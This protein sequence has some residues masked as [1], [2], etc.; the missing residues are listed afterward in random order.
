MK[1]KHHRHG[2]CNTAG[3]SGRF[4]VDSVIDRFNFGTKVNISR[5]IDFDNFLSHLS[6]SSN[7]QFLF[8]VI[9]N[10]INVFIYSKAS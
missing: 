1:Q 7:S 2:E 9:R 8:N 3:K 10:N 5:N 4:I 6:D